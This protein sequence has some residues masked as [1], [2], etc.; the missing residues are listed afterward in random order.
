M[1]RSPPRRRSRYNA[2]GNPAGPRRGPVP[3]PGPVRGPIPI[4]GP[5][6]GPISGRGP[7]PAAF[8]PI[9]I[10]VIVVDGPVGRSRACG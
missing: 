3:V 2:A 5:V 4:R 6:R 1:L 7:V 9:A 10:L 8:R